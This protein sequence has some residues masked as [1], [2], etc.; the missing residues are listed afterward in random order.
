M[1]ATGTIDTFDL[2]FG[3]GGASDL[4]GQDWSSDPL[5]GNVQYT[6]SGTFTVTLTV[7]DTSGNRS[8][9]V[10]QLVTIVDD[11]DEEVVIPVPPAETPATSAR[12]YIATSDT[13][14][15]TYTPTNSPATANTGLS[16]GDLNVNMGKLNPYY[17]NLGI[18]QHHYLMCND[19]G[20]ALSI[21]GCTTYTKI[22]KATLGDPTNTAGDVSPPDTDDLD[23]I[24]I[25]FDPQDINRI[26]CLRLTNSTWNAS[27]D[28]RAYLYWSDDYGTTWLSFGIGA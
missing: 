7:T 11:T 1:S 16:G 13:G 14:I 9:A 22:T 27:N 26:Y 2:T 12:I 3:G 5:T 25:T 15:F 20:I 17:A 19:N 21:N 24:S 4:T 10:T 23:E 18:G 8:Q 6:S 28:P